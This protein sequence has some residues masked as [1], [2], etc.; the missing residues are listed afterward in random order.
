M[1]YPRRRCQ[2]WAHRE[3]LDANSVSWPGEHWQ[4]STTRVAI[5]PASLSAALILLEPSRA[6]NHPQLQHRRVMVFFGH[7]ERTKA[8]R[9]PRIGS[10]LMWGVLSHRFRKEFQHWPSQAYS[11]SVQREERTSSL[12]WDLFLTPCPLA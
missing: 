3:Q 5:A 12:S 4:V 10:M 9:N 1:S 2:T 6:T 11:L 8:V 7:A